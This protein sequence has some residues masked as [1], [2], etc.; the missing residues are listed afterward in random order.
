MD[1]FERTIDELETLFV[2][3]VFK[4]TIESVHEMNEMIRDQPVTESEAA[5]IIAS[6]NLQWRQNGY[7]N[8]MVHVSGEMV[9]GGGL[10]DIVYTDGSQP[11]PGYYDN[12]PVQS[13]GFG[14]E[15]TTSLEDGVLTYRQ[16]IVMKGRIELPDENGI[17]G[18]TNEACTVPV[19]P[20]VIIEC[21]EDTPQKIAAWLEV[22]HPDTKNLIDECIIQADDEAGAI[23]NL[24]D[25]PLSLP[26]GSKKEIREVK[27]HL[28]DYISDYIT[29][30]QHI[31]YRAVLFGPI[32]LFNAETLSWED[33]DAMSEKHSLLNIQKAS[34]THNRPTQ[35]FKIWLEAS[36]IVGSKID[37]MTV[38]IPLSTL[39]SL[40]SGR[41]ILRAE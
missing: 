8:R 13:K 30:E 24:R 41:E 26:E 16:V 10:E 20:E 15:V 21:Y 9:V 2:D 34:I 17:G 25:T 3:P 11:D 14:M 18:V 35:E 19:V 38:K 1:E 37:V 7:Y 39:E 5:Q 33:H 28:N 22:Y 32:K 36:I 29:F 6:L 27:Q 23:I 31:P 40:E 4:A 12:Q